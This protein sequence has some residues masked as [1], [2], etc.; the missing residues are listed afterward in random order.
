MDSDGATDMEAVWKSF[1]QISLGK[2]DMICGVRDRQLCKRSLIRGI[3]GKIFSTCSQ[4]FAGTN[5]AD[6]QCGF[7]V[8]TRDC[9]RQIFTNIHLKGWAFDV[10]LLLIAKK[11]RKGLDYIPVKWT[12]EPGSKL[13]IGRDSIRMLLDMSLMRILYMTGVWSIS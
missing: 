6:T 10:E 5:I 13:S 1:D 9:A 7:K 4:I 8:L 11:L 3:T 12:E 2:C